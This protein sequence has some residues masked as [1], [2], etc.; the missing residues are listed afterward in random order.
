ML[1]LIA[2]TIKIRQVVLNDMPLDLNFVR[3]PRADR[4]QTCHAAADLPGYEE[5]PQPFRS[6]PRLDLF[7]GSSSA[8]PL[9]RFR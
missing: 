1:D 9:D 4:C 3:I 8:H 2:P 6:H 7:V 5:F